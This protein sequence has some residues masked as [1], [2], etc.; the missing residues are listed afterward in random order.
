MSTAC[1][2]SGCCSV[3]QQEPS[4]N[5]LLVTQIKSSSAVQVSQLA[6]DQHAV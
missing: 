4:V 6:M 5:L 3:K 1:S 2:L